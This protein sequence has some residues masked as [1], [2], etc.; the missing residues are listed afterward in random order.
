MSDSSQ[1]EALFSQDSPDPLEPVGQTMEE[2]QLS[3]L[4]GFMVM[5]VLLHDRLVSLLLLMIL[6]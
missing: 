3:V 5:L 2:V 4:L 6:R 1:Q